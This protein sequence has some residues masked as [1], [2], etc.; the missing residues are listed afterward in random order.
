ME[1]KPA[2]QQPLESIDSI[3]DSFFASSCIGKQIPTG[4]RYLRVGAH[5]RDYLEMEGERILCAEDAELLD[6]ERSLD[7]DSAF[8]RLFGAEVLAYLLSGFLEPEWLLPDL[9]DRRTQISLTPRLIQW[10][11]NCRLLDPRR[12]RAA[13]HSTRAAAA[14]ARRGPARG[15]PR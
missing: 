7:P 12:D 3:L 15:G 10:L 11:C 14:W 2:G 4:V 6:L 1:Q 13:I 5:L 9:Q 8:A